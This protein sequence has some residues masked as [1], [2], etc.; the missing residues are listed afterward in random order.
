M[1]TTHLRKLVQQGQLAVESNPSLPVIK[2]LLGIVFF[3]L[4]SSELTEL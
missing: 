4:N 1:M 2:K 3:F